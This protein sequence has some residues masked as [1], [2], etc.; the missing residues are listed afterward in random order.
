MSRT[1]LA[2]A[3]V[4]VSGC[5]GELGEW[6][7]PVDAETPDPMADVAGDA[8]APDASDDDSSRDDD[9]V[10]TG[11]DVS[12]DAASDAAPDAPLDV[13]PRDVQA[14][15][16]PRDAPPPPP[17]TPMVP[18]CTG[19]ASGQS[20]VWTCTSDRAARQRCVSGTTE[21]VRCAS[22]CVA[23]AGGAVC[24]CGSMAGFTVWNCLPSGNLG[25]CQGGA[26]IEQSCM[27]NGC[28]ARPTGVDDVCNGPPPPPG[29]LD[30]ASLQWWNSSLTYQHVSSGWVDTDLNVVAGTRVQLR[31]NARLDRHGVYGWGYMPEFTDMVTG[32]RFRFLHLRPQNQYATTVGRVYP[33]GYIVGLS[34]GNTAD[35]GYPTYSTGQ[36]LCVQTLI[37]YRSAFPTG[38]DACR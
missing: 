7:A 9:V 38:R 29:T 33:A 6:G 4:C 22:G 21:T 31:H 12:L 2:L 15:A 27:G 11:P 5:A 34:G 24:S 18:R 20:D 13:A 10:V 25:R 8:L 36:H 30:C 19:S 3:L 1:T 26:W 23:A 17:D 28:S 37:A 35:T 32:A 16:A 14:D